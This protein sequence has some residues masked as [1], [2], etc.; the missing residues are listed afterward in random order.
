MKKIIPVILSG[1]FGTRLWPLSREH[2]PKQFNEEIISP[3]F[4]KRTHNLVST[5][6]FSLPVIVSN[7]NHR[8]LVEDAINEAYDTMILEPCSKNTAPA[9]LAA[10]MLI[11]K[12]Y[13]SNATMLVLPSDHLISDQHAFIQSVQNGLKMI[14]T[15]IVTFGVK[16]SRPETGYGYIEI[17]P[18]T[19]AGT[20]LFNITQFKEKP[21]KETAQS[22]I[23]H[24]NFYWNAGIFLFNSSVYIQMCK[25]LIPETFNLAMES[26]NNATIDSKKIN[27][28]EAFND[29]KSESIDYAV[30][31]KASNIVM[32]E[33]LSSWS[34]VG[35]FESLYSVLQPDVERNV[36]RGNVQ[37]M[38]TTGCFIQ[39]NTTNLLSV[40]GLQDTIVI[41]TN[42]ATLVSPM[43]YSQEIKSL[44]ENLKDPSKK[45]ES[46]KVHRPWGTYE[47]LQEYESCKIKKITVHPR[48]ALSLQ[49]H[50]HRSE[51]WV[52][53][54]GIA[55][56]I[57]GDSTIQMTVG[58][59]VFIPAHTKHR[60]QNTTNENIE[61][62]EVQT[63]DYLGEDDIIRY[64]DDWGRE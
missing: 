49:S 54:K 5:P 29:I 37:A 28:S 61:I 35:S 32:A 39:N 19:I 17:E 60:L 4:F 63:G 31:E 12:K 20:H 51:N 33:M 64:Q 9:I 15:H 26:S 1:G 48:K 40:Y 56:V 16:P 25:E 58:Q 52:V 55:T 6:E 13:G 21:N 30:L 41:Q 53:I 44:V 43:Q 18:T 34:D 2:M 62:I 24:G 8:Y 7:T 36:L 23:E 38:K 14:D 45:T 3:S 47:V 42:D 10:A 27:L 59:S 46:T 50:K 11:E 22:F 57:T